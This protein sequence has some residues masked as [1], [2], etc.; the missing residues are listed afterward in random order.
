[1]TK[2]IEQK[3]EQARIRKQRQ[4]ARESGKEPRLSG[5]QITTAGAQGPMTPWFTDY[6]FRK[7]DGNFYEALREGIPLFDAAVRRLI[8]LNGTIKII[9]EKMTC[10]TALEDFCLSVPV[11]DM[12]K[13]IHAFKENAENETFEQGFS[14]SEFL[15]NQKQDD[16]ERLVVADSK[17]IT[18]RKNAAG[19]MEPWFRTGTPATTN[20][21]MPSGIINEIMNARYGQSLSYNGVDETRL[22]PDNKLYFSINNENQNP[23]G[24]SLFR[25]TEFVAQVRVTIQN[26]FKNIAER[27]GDPMHHVHYKGKA[28]EKNLEDRRKTLENDFKSIVTAKRSGK[29]GDLVTAGGPDSDVSIKLIGLD[30]NIY[31]FDIPLRNLTEECVAKFGLPAWMLGIYWSTTERMATL[32]VE[33]ALA[34]AKIRQAAMLPEYIRL[35]SNFLKLRGLSWKSITTSLDRKGDWGIIFESPNVRDVVAQAQAQ[36]LLAEADNMRRGGTGTPSATT[37]NT[38]TQVPAAGAASFDINGMKFEIKTTPGIQAPMLPEPVASSLKVKVDEPDHK[39]S[40]TCDHHSKLKTPNSQCS[41][42]KSH[43][44]SSILNIKSV[45]KE[46]MRPVPWPQLDEWEQKYEQNLKDD[47]LI[48]QENCFA[49]LGLKIPAAEGQSASSNVQGLKIKPGV[50]SPS[51]PPFMAAPSQEQATVPREIKAFS[52][53]DAQRA[54]LLKTLKEYLGWY[55]PANEDSSITWYY[56]QAYSAGLI[57][58]A[59]MVGKEKPLL[60][61]LKNQEI[62]ADL[63]TNGFQ[64]V[65]DNATRVIRN[66][67]MDQMELGMTQGVN[68]RDV[69][70]TL[71]DIFDAQNSDWERLARTEMSGA[72]ERAKLDEW[73]ERGVDVSNAVTV[74]VHPRCRCSTTVEDDG[75]GNFRAVFAPAPDACPW[76]LSLQEGD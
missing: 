29:S 24:V 40:C 17:Q 71:S 13:G 48:L 39:A 50:Y 27:F 6:V 72:A 22:S 20:Y 8:T 49:I 21:T 43:F 45:A 2:P 38:A 73:K 18:F 37:V 42:G 16:I 33:M 56:A 69:A 1:M 67:V 9:G 66:E 4:R 75:K 70:R 59:N 15:M 31:T 7:V 46:L 51:A 26:S 12:Q 34:D 57:Q 10:V 65:K 55:D 63:V 54:A 64:L 61:I 14:I 60:D 74:P 28:G 36:F 53:D 25:S 41:C 30:G 5:S 68:P 44:K 58:A 3:R 23:Y 76:C 11:N 52:F 35:F 62:Y 19:R 32:E 47:W